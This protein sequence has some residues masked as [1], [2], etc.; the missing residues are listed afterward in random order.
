MSSYPA[1]L[2][3]MHGWK[4]AIYDGDTIRQR[5]VSLHGP[6]GLAMHPVMN[7]L[8]FHGIDTPERRPSSRAPDG[9]RRTQAEKNREKEMAYLA[10]DLVYEMISEADE[11]LWVSTHRDAIWHEPGSEDIGKY[12][13]LLGHV[14]ADGINVSKELIEGALAVPYDGGKKTH[15]WGAQ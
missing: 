15:D 8:R 2:K 3:P 12:G 11:V 14:I 13:G 5:H 10:T 6:Y 9:S 7:R 4:K 1:R